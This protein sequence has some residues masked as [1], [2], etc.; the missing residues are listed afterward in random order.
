M[1]YFKI[2]QL[3]IYTCEQHTARQSFL[4]YTKFHLNIIADAQQQY[5]FPVCWLKIWFV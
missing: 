2:T 3:G 1:E 5:C 4:Q